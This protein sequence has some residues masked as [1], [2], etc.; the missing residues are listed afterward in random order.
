[1]KDKYF[2]IIMLIERLHRLFLDVVKTELDRHNIL[3]INNIQ[4]LILYNVGH[5]KLSIGE[6]SNRGY[7]LGSNVTYN[8]KKMVENGYLEQETSEHDRRSSYVKL[9]KKGNNLYR[10]I[11]QMFDKHMANLEHNNIKVDDLKKLYSTME[12]LE[13][14]WAFMLARD[15]RF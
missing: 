2:S 3:D 12:Q 10:I 9:S 5:N 13:S 15:M 14:F 6:V 1:M 4:C 8:L 7:Y 11:E